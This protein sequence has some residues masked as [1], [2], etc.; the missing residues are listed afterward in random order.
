LILD[1]EGR[2][3]AV[4]VGQPDDPKWIDVVGDA[5][6]VMPEVQRLGI[7]MELFAD[8]NLR[9]R[10]GEFLAIPVGV[11]FGGGQTV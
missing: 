1:K 5:A 7:D 4:L 9:H 8:K 6:E 10:R 3:I 11:S 2:I